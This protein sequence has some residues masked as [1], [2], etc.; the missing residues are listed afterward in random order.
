MSR[1]IPAMLV[2]LFLLAAAPHSNA[3][4]DQPD[5]PQTRRL[6]FASCARPMYPQDDLRAAHQGT[7]TLGFLVNR[8]GTVAE[9]RVTKSSGHPGLD[10]AAPQA[11]VQC[12]FN[13]A[14]RDTKDQ[15]WV[16]VQYVWTLH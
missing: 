5:P 8:D 1:T 4:V 11:F 9:V 13:V 10:D 16:P 14:D 12:R 6:D 3:T 15:V 2:S 7:V